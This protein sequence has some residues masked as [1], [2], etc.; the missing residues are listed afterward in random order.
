MASIVKVER[1]A[2]AYKAPKEKKFKPFNIKLRF[3]GRDDALNFALAIENYD[4]EISKDITE[5]AYR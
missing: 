1:K 4:D 5:Q 3:E 2:K